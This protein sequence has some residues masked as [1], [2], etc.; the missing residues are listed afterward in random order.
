MRARRSA[1]PGACGTGPARG[2][3]VHGFSLIEVLFALA[4]VGLA[5]GAAAST[6][7]TALMSGAITSGIDEALQLAGGKLAEAGADIPLRA[8]VT[9]G[10]AGRFRWRVAISPQPDAETP[11]NF[12]LY[13]IE[14]QVAWRDGLRE[15]EVALDTMRLGRAPAP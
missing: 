15:R 10:I 4:V 8:G 6:F 9:S 7:R 1:D 13:R 3:A 14:A 2:R 11:S 12:A 5:L